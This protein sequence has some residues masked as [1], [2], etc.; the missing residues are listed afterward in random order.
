MR[1]LPRRRRGRGRGASRPAPTRSTPATASSP[2]GPRSPRALEDAGIKLVGPSAAVMEQMGRKD[3]AREIAVRPPASPWCPSTTWPTTRSRTCASPCWSRPP[4]A[5]AARGCG[6]SAS[7]ASSPR[8]W[9]P[10]RREAASAFGDDTLLVEKYVERGRHIEVQVLADAHG[11]VRAPLRARLL[12]P[13]PPPEGAG[14]GAGPDD[15]RGD[16]GGR[17][18]GGRRAGREPSATRTPAPWSSCSTSATGEVYFLEMNTRLQVEHPVTEAVVVCAGE[19]VDLVALQLR[20]RRGRAAAVRPGRPRPATGTPSRPG[21]TPRTPSPASCPRPARPPWCAG[22]P[23][24]GSTTRWRAARSSARRTTRCSARSSSTAPTGRRPAGRWSPRSTTPRSSGLTTNVGFLRA[25]AAGEEFRDATIDTAWL[26]RHTIAEP[27]PRDCPGD[28]GLDRGVRAGRGRRRRAPVPRRRLARWAPSPR[29]WWS[30]STG[31]CWSTAARGLVDETRA[32]SELSAEHH[33]VVLRH[34]RRAG[35]RAVVNVGAAQRRGRAPAGTATSSS[36]PT[37]S[38]TTPLDAS[39]GAIAGADAR[40][41]ARRARR[42]RARPS[43]RATC[44][45]RWRR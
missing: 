38:A 33:T 5:A 13:A 17:H 21:S 28:R 40:H 39:D 43:P 31:R 44:S 27:S 37:S 8:R 15:H 20:G 29:R 14:G 16:P 25:L 10:P 12:H 34:R 32:S 11:N 35:D 2:S 42:P 3:A 30:S 45:A 18:R 7:P 23:G 41:R 1:E 4:P 36:A 6:W 9:P 19:H 26:D 22:R 24:P